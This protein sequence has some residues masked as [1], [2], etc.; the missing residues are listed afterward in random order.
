MIDATV[1]G[2]TRVVAG[3]LAALRSALITA[4]AASNSARGSGEAVVCRSGG[5]GD[6]CGAVGEFGLREGRPRRTRRRIRGRRRT[7]SGPCRLRSASDHWEHVGAGTARGLFTHER[8]APCRSG[9]HRMVAVRHSA[10]AAELGGR[11]KRVTK[12]ERAWS[13]TPRASVL[14]HRHDARSPRERRMLD[15]HP[16]LVEA[17]AE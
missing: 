5:C 15:R 10:L 9:T 17:A 1:A 7:L 2:S 12:A 14:D 11:S 6:G 3:A 16:G 4:E 13:E 8:D